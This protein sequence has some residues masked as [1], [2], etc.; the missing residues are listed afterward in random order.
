MTNDWQ[1][2]RV[3]DKTEAPVILPKTNRPEPTGITFRR[4]HAGG[5]LVFRFAIESQDGWLSLAGPEPTS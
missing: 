4:R 1:L 3:G 5:L 2:L